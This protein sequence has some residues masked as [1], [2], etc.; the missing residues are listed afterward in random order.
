[1]LLWTMFLEEKRM[2]HKLKFLRQSK[3]LVSCGETIVDVYQCMICKKLS[4]IDNKT[5]KKVSF[6]GAMGEEV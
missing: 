2:K 6:D 1:M 3:V 4:I 5:G